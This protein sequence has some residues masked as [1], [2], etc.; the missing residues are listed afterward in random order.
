MDIILFLAVLVLI[1]VGMWKA[2]EKAD[3]P[4]WACII[5][6]YNL[7]ILCVMAGKPGWWVLLMC[8][9]LVNFV[10]SIIVFLEIARR[11]GQS[12]LFGV[13]G[14]AFFGFIGWPILGFGD[15]EYSA[16]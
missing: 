10:V 7:Y 1:V 9:P 15:A 14:L 2:F 13:F 6:I 3:Q 16:S 12:A 8:I 11:F 5:P 4:G